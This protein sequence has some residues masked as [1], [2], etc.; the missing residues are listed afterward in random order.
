V[1]TVGLG[2]GLGLACGVAIS[3]GVGVAE[4]TLRTSGQS[5]PINKFIP[6]VIV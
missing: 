2:L 1:V 3:E 5:L 4:E 6:L